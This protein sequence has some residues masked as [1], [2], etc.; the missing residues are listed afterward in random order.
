MLPT[1]RTLRL[2]LYSLLIVAG[3]VLAASLA[4][5]HAE[6]QALEEDATRANQ[7]LAL[8]A[9]S[10]HTLIDRYRALPAVLALDPELRAAL[11]GPVTP[12]Q[13]DANWKKS[14]VPRSPR[15]WSCSTA[16][17]WPWPP[18]IGVCPAVTSATTTVFAP[19]SARPAPRAP[20]AFMRWG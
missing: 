9:N 17:A 7:Q 1:S 12:E 8:Y 11:D 14:T 6:R 13:Q 19:T 2:S 20:G 15:P 5:R 18:A 3:A 10:L 16:P 4:I